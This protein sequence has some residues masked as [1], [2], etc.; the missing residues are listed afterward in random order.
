MGLELP[1]QHQAD[2][3]QSWCSVRGR[4]V[5][6]ATLVI[7]SLSITLVFGSQIVA[8]PNTQASSGAITA[9][10][11]LVHQGPASHNNNNNNNNNKNNKNSGGVPT[12]PGSLC[13]RPPTVAPP[14]LLRADAEAVCS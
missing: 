5:P 2:A 4:A 3:G 11:N 9:G 10:T 12:K 1:G 8:S 14:P 6:V 7:T 13:P